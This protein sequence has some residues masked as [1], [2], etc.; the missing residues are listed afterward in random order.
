MY[1]RAARHG[2]QVQ[3]HIVGDASMEVIVDLLDTVNQETA[4][5]PLRWVLM[6]LFLPTGHGIARMRDIGLLASVQDH[7]LLLGF[8]Q[9]RWWGA[10]RGRS[11]SGRSWTP[12]SSPAAGPTRR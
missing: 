7:P 12:V 5:A 10:G 8:N 2:F 9:V 3:T 4:L 11:R 6:H 1:R